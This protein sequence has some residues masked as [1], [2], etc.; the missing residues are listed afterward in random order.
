MARVKTNSKA[1]VKNTE[2]NLHCEDCELAYDFHEKDYRGLFFMCKCPYF[3]FS[4]FLW[5]D[6]CDNLKPK[7]K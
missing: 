1:L 4:K 7:K 5:H 2:D 3:E 6:R